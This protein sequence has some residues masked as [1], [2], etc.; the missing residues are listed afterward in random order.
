MIEVE[1]LTKDYGNFQAV[2]DL[3]FK[4]NKGEIV[5]FLGPNGAGKTTTM[6]ILTGYMPPTSG[7]ARIAG[8]DVFFESLKVREHIGYLPETVP[9]YT[10]MTV[11]AYLD[12]MAKLHHVPHRRDRIYEVMEQTNIEDHGDFLIGKL[13]KGYRQRVGLSQA[14]LHDPEVLI[15]DEP[16]IGLD[17]RQIIDVRELIKSLA[18]NHT[19]VLSTH[20]L[21]E[22]S[23]TCQRVLIINQG[24]LVAED[25]PEHLTARLK[26]NERVFLH[27]ANPPQHPED[28]TAAVP[29][30]LTAESRGD[31]RFEVECA[32]GDD[33]RPEIA[34]VVV[35]KGWGLL[36]LR[37]LSMSLEE[38]FL[39]LTTDQDEEYEE[40]E[41]MAETDEEE[42]ED[43]VIRNI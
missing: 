7:T 37:P 9:L 25:T 8:Y 43:A 18:Q 15:L 17:P 38:I 42:E 28:L 32:L 13:S 39:Q 27:L 6:R 19:V 41:Q 35:R 34:E 20:I 31:G 40:E 30:I 2:R 10:D 4:I 24:Q 12:F 14:L 29:G 11:G 21:T 23:Q 16:T 3:S 22:V 1:H 33:R 26:G 5:G 36:E